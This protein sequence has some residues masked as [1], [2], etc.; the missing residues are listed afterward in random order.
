MKMQ[1]FSIYDH[2]AECYQQKFSCV[3][4][5]AAI[6]MIKTGLMENPQSSFMRHN[7]NDFSLYLVSSFD[8]ATGETVQK[9]NW[10]QKIMPI[11]QIMAEIKAENPQFDLELPER[12]PSIDPRQA[13]AGMAKRMAENGADVQEVSE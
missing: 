3:N 7:P 4:A 9:Q 2:V 11:S 5:G 10:P 12:S 8:D 1:E 13:V 6:R